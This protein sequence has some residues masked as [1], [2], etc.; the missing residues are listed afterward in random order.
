MPRDYEEYVRVTGFGK[1][2]NPTTINLIRVGKDTHDIRN[3]SDGVYIELSGEGGETL[4]FNMDTSTA[5]RIAGHI[6]KY[7]DE[8]DKETG[9]G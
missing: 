5:R 1:P 7:A 3:L 2:E 9:R 4:R 6:V 8:V